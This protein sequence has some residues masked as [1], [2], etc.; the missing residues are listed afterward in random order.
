MCVIFSSN[1]EKLNLLVP[2]LAP[3]DIIL[4]FHCR[5]LKELIDTNLYFT[6]QLNYEILERKNEGIP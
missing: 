4:S 6:F 5:A 1:Y 2:I 3:I